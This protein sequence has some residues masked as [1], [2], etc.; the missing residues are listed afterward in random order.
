[1]GTWWQVSARVLCMVSCCA[2]AVALAAGCSGGGNSGA[3][4]DETGRL[5][6]ALTARGESG[7]LYRLREGFFQ[8]SQRGGGFT[9]FSTEEEPLAS[10]FELT[11]ASG[12]YVI[13]LFEG[14]RLEKID[15]G[16]VEMVV[17]ELVSPPTQ[18]FR[19]QKDEETALTYRFATSGEII[20]LGLGRLA[21]DIAVDEGGIGSGSRLG[22]PLS[23]LDGQLHAGS[24][25][26]GIQAAVFTQA[27][28]PGGRIE[29]TRDTGE[30]C[31]TGSLAPGISQDLSEQPSALFG[32][33]FMSSAGE[34]Q[35]WDL[36]GGNVEG[37]AFII[38]GPLIPPFRF[39]A[40]PG[41]PQSGDENFCIGLGASSGAEFG[42]HFTRLDRNCRFPRGRDPLVTDNL[43][44]I[45]WSVAAW[46]DEPVSFDFCIGSLRPMLRPE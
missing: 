13:D 11:L 22:A 2:G 10:Q 25:P 42:L 27:A 34:A 1:M 20:E 40:L 37:I 8:I 15:G 30:L 38:T 24:N 32:L 39:G 35:P 26:Y 44:H 19:I 21:V 41:N 45:N 28:P 12:A 31:V 6:L 9:T 23:I 17:A 33:E 7:S 5:Q 18:L 16:G 46:P 36:D 3:E 4:A 14:W 29:L 43:Q